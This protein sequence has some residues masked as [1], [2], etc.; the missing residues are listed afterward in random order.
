MMKDMDINKIGKE[1]KY[2]SP[3]LETVIMT[4]SCS[5]LEDSGN[6]EQGENGGQIDPWHPTNP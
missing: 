2:V 4:V 6:T 1:G 5:L 3:Q